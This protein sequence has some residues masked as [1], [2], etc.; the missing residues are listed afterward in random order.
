[1]KFLGESLR[2]Q[3]V[4]ELSQLVEIDARL[5]AERVRDRS[6]GRMIPDGSGLTQSSANCAVYSFLERNPKLA[7]LPFQEPREI[8]IERQRGPHD[9]HRDAALL[10]VKTSGTSCARLG[11]A[12]YLGEVPSVFYPN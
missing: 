4:S 2:L 12:R 9:I 10:D 3:F 1:M 5:E 8:I 11:F 6:W 7:R